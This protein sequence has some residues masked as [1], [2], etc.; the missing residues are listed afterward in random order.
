[1]RVK[2]TLLL[3]TF[4]AFVMLFAANVRAGDQPPAETPSPEA[5]AAADILG[6]APLALILATGQ[7]YLDKRRWPT[8]LRDIRYVIESNTRVLPK[9]F[10]FRTVTFAPQSRKECIIAFT[11]DWPTLEGGGAEG[12]IVVRS[13]GSL[14][15]IAKSSTVTWAKPPKLRADLQPGGTPAADAKAGGSTGP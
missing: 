9:D 15:S 10:A 12:R 7:H 5:I 8:E 14:K 13:G 4:A 1:M 3:A 2:P 6:K 11:F